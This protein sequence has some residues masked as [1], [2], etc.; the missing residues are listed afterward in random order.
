MGRGA[1]RGGWC[2]SGCSSHLQGL[3][4]RKPGLS[5]VRGPLETWDRGP[6]AMLGARVM[7]SWGQGMGLGLSPSSALTGSGTDSCSCG[8]GRKGLDCH[9]LCKGER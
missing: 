2:A 4:V 3:V 9:G 7:G 8:V 1:G 5:P 6:G